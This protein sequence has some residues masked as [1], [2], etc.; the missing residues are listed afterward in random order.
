MKSARDRSPTPDGKRR[1]LEALRDSD[2]RLPRNEGEADSRMKMLAEQGRIGEC[3]DARV[4]ADFDFSRREFRVCVAAKT[5]VN[6]SGAW[7]SRRLGSGRLC[8]GSECRHGPAESAQRPARFA[9]SSALREKHCRDDTR[10]SENDVPLRDS[11][12][13][14]HDR[15]PRWRRGDPRVAPLRIRRLVAVEDHLSGEALTWQKKLRV[16]LR[17]TLE[18][19]FP[20]DFTQ[21]VT[22]H[23]VEQVTQRLAYVRQHPVIPRPVASDSTSA[24]PSAS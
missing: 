15:A 14:R 5:L 21:Q 20:R 8:M 1:F 9:R 12:P 13:A 22:L 19:A 2:S 7:S 4:I 18:F 17:W 10:P 24:L 3:G 23:G 11:R 6:A 16:A